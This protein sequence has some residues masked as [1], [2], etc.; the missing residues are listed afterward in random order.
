MSDCKA[1]GT[2]PAE[3]PWAC[4]VELGTKIKA[5]APK[6]ELLQIAAQIV[7][8]IGALLPPSREGLVGADSPSEAQDVIAES[9]DVLTA[10]DEL[11]Q[12]APAENAVEASTSSV[13][14]SILIPLLLRL[15]PYLLK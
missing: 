13:S 7:G 11:I 15:L 12:A 1:V 4:V 14:L 3:V 9:Q 10:A 2:F 6:G 5:G 8:Q